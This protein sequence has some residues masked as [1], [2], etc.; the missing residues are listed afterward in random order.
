MNPAILENAR[1]KAWALAMQARV[2]AWHA[3]IE[4]MCMAEARNL[5]L[6]CRRRDPSADPQLNLI[7]S[8]FEIDDL[9]E[10]HPDDLDAAEV[11]VIQSFTEKRSSSLVRSRLDSFKYD[12]QRLSEM[13][14]QPAPLLNQLITNQER[15]VSGLTLLADAMDALDRNELLAVLVEPVSKFARSVFVESTGLELPEDLNGT[16]DTLRYW[17]RIRN[18]GMAKQKFF[19]SFSEAAKRFANY[20]KVGDTVDG[21]RVLK[22]IANEGMVSELLD[23]YV[24]IPN[25]REVPMCEFNFSKNSYSDTMKGRIQE[26]SEIIEVDREI[27]P[28][29]V[30]VGKDGPY[31]LKGGD[32]RA[33]AM[34]LL[35]VRSLPALVVID[36][37][38]PEAAMAVELI[39]TPAATLRPRR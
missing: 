2:E 24:T 4:K 38:K 37:A 8:D 3:R 23:E 36:M 5:Y 19:E 12:L 9:F 33:E 21:L 10:E 16:T 7:H 25:V 35:G 39:E 34:Y 11:E 28:I 15:E 30:V 32:T 20:P 13:C 17:I 31:I 27:N 26:L 29:V 1:T 6:G 14:A 22:R 18:E